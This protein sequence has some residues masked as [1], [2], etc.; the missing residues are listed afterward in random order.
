MEE[1]GKNLYLMDG[2]SYIYR[3]YHALPSFHTRNGFPT[4]AI[5]GFTNMLFRLLKEFQ[6]LYLSIAFDPPGPTWRHTKMPE[7]KSQRPPVP[8]DLKP[9]IPII[10]EIITAMG[11]NFIEKEGYE[12]DDVLATIAI[13][14]KKTFHQVIIFTTDK[15]ALQLVDERVSVVNTF[16][17]NGWYTPK[18]VREKL[19]VFPNQVVDYLAIVGDSIDNIPGIPGIGEKTAQKLLEEWGNLE[20]ILKNCDKIKKVG[21]KIYQ[22]K[23]TLLRNKELIE[24]KKVPLNINWEEF[25]IKER[26]YQKL[27]EIFKKLEFRKLLEKIQEKK[28]LFS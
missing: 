26:N 24:W 5:F 10:K 2:S 9:Q 6:P 12:A 8:D 14:G 19:G 21:D 1:R 23:S 22:Y 13:E 15:D 4:N 20:K 27:E 28:T 25:K 18:K 3:A 11:I 16:V 7:Y 17:K